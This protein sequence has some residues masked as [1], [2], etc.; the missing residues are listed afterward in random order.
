MLDHATHYKAYASRDPRFDG[1]FF[2]AVKTTG[3]YCRPV[4]NAKPPREKNCLFFA[5]AAE[6]EGEGFRP[7]LK[8]RPEFAP[9][10]VAAGGAERLAQWAATQLR[11]QALG[12]QGGM[13]ALAWRAGVSERHLRRIVTEQLGTSPVQLAQTARLLTAKHLLT[14]TRMPVERVAQASGFGSLRRMQTMLRARYGLSATRLRQGKEKPAASDRPQTDMQLKLAYRPPH[15]WG[16]LLGFLGGRAIP[17]VE[18]VDAEEGFSGGR[19]ARTW[20]SAVDP[21]ATGWW[22]VSR[23]GGDDGWIVV[24]LAESLS[25]CAAEVLAC[26]RR[27]FDLDAQPAAIDAALMEDER[28]R[29]L[30]RRRPGLRVP[31]GADGFELALR[32]ILGQQVSVAAAR[33]LAGRVAASFGE[34]IVTPV[35]GL[36]RLTPRAERVV[37]AGVAALSGLGLTGARAKSVSVLAKRVADGELVIGPAPEPERVMEELRKCP[38]IGPWTASYIAMRGLGWPDAF[39]AGDLV[40]RRVLGDVSEKRAEEL[41]KRWSPWRAYAAMHVW[42]EAG[43]RAAEVAKQKREKR[44]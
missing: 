6:A 38:G 9:G 4:C 2:V 39:P 44:G 21:K 22:R 10:V 32:A 28:L 30:V 19:Y 11:G 14:D 16:K 27:V 42:N 5:T 24:E 36:T 8:C 7:C 37:Q 41:S 31:G 12:D 18:V 26:V 1:V 25:P 15:Q 17:G 23:P 13:A 20:R 3:I 40:L 35:E 29:E 43:E 33:T 34:E